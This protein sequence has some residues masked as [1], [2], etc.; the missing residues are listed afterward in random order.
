MKVHLGADWMAIVV[1]I[2]RLAISRTRVR[3]STGRRPK[4]VKDRVIAL[5]D[6]TKEECLLLM[7][8]IER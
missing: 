4:E 1:F 5:L 2:A 6:T 8:P 7:H 3:T